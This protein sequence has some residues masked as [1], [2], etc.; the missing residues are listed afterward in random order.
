MKRTRY[1]CRILI[2][3]GFYRQI[4]GKAQISRLIKTRLFRAE[5]LHA[6][7]R[8]DGHEAKSRFLH[9]RESV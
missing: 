8:T 9:F 2:K 1:Y 4:L 7:G 5:M 3:F 6:D